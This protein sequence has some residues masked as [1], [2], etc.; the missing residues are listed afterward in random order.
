MSDHKNSD[1][2]SHQEPSQNQKRDNQKSK[3]WIM[4]ALIFGWVA[5]IWIITMVKMGQN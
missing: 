3:N 4:L 1:H 5:L 2:I